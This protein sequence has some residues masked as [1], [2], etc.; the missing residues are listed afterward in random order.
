MGTVSFLYFWLYE[1]LS[2]SYRTF[3]LLTIALSYGVNLIN[4]P[5]MLLFFA[6]YAAFGCVLTLDFFFSAVSIP[7]RCIYPFKDS[8]KAVLLSGFELVGMRFILM[9]VRMNALSGYK[10]KREVWGELERFENNR[11]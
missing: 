1:L 3:G 9:L 11:D 7:N 5:F 10:K 6:V 4:E 8:V 2:P